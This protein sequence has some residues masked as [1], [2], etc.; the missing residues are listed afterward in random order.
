MGPVRNL[1]TAHIWPYYLPLWELSWGCWAF[2]RPG[3]VPTGGWAGQ[4]RPVVWDVPM[5]S[6]L[7]DRLFGYRVLASHEILFSVPFEVPVLFA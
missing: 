4:F 2:P 5:D 7:R 6:L 1:P 3:T